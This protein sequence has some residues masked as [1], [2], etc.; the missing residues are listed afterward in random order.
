MK[1]V[2]VVA[3]LLALGACGNDR[4][5]FVP[6]ASGELASSFLKKLGNVGLARG[7][8]QKDPSAALGEYVEAVRR[9]E[10]RAAVEAL[11]RWSRATYCLS[12]N[13]ALVLGQG[14]AEAA[15][16]SLGRGEAH[17]AFFALLANP[18]VILHDRTKFVG[19]T[20]LY[21]FLVKHRQEFV[22]SALAE[23]SAIG[24]H[25]L[26]LEDRAG[27][28]LV[29]VGPL[30]EHT[31]AAD[32]ISASHLLD[33]LTRGFR[34]G[35]GGCAALD[36]IRV[37]FDAQVGYSCEQ[38]TCEARTDSAP[39]AIQEMHDVG[40]T[41][42]GVSVEDLEA[43]FGCAGG[44]SGSSSGGGGIGPG[45]TGCVT[46]DFATSASSGL[47]GCGRALVEGFQTLGWLTPAPGSS[48]MPQSCGDPRAAGGG[49]TPEKKEQE[50]KEQEKKAKEERDQATGQ[51]QASSTCT[52]AA[53]TA[54]EAG[55]DKVNKKT[56]AQVAAAAQQAGADPKK[57]T[58]ANAER[59]MKAATT[60]TPVTVVRY[61]NVCPTSDHCHVKGEGI[62][63]Q[64]GIDYEVTDAAGATAHEMGHEIATQLGVPL[65]RQHGF[66]DLLGIQEVNG[67]MSW[68][69]RDVKPGTPEW[70]KG[71]RDKKYCV[72]DDNGCSEVCTAHDVLLQNFVTCL[73]DNAAKPPQLPPGRGVIDPSPLDPPVASGGLDMSACF[74]TLPHVS[75]KCFA[76]DC[77]PEK[78]PKLVKGRC[79][80][81]GGDTGLTGA[82]RQIPA[83]CGAVD[84]GPDSVPVTSG[85][86]CL[87]SG[88]L[89]GRP[90]RKPIT[91]VD[92]VVNPAD[93]KHRQ[94]IR[95]GPPATHP[96][97]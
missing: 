68:E 64:G 11:N 36:M 55:A 43:A 91:P 12:L 92:I 28:R 37:P 58:E 22:A 54:R 15:E 79:V 5:I 31:V 7:C 93:R 89:D 81:S 82:G 53:S 97:R 39:P 19:E 20:P 71:R 86:S 33:A 3:C 72:G 70:D 38:S 26:W 62:F 66:N 34:L 49:T 10:R 16:S 77:G 40:F 8:D 29:Q 14:I 6:T 87:C 21:R 96:S 47:L 27:R 48:G 67:S 74:A 32:C 17:A 41:Q 76:V 30:C 13:D 83:R 90:G 56:P 25:G 18:I 50:K 35:Y 75:P 94:R 46:G 42:F 80:C 78:S 59:A 2:L 88:G 52:Q 44:S 84:C 23:H 95:G 61:Q 4:R 65:E 1:R 51:C 9:S 63:V 73:V 57:A 24:L 69:G 85:G 45:R 60:K